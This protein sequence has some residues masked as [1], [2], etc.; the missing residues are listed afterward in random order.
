MKLK[1]CM[2][3]PNSAPVRVMMV[4]NFDINN[5]SGCR[6]SSSS[7]VEQMDKRSGYGSQ[8]EDFLDSLH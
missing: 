8:P 4:L 7:F 1:E 3:E 2:R 6:R 5:Y